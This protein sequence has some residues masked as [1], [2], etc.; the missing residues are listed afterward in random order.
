MYS[1]RF[2]NIDLNENLGAFAAATCSAFIGA[3]LGNLLLKK[4]AKNGSAHRD[5]DVVA[6]VRIGLRIS[7]I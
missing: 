5:R 6:L 4:V 2:S 1:T 7:I 3:Y